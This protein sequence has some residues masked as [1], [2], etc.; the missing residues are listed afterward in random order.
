M[1]AN[2]K[3]PHILCINHSPEILQLL[4][5]LLESEG[6]QV[7]T[8][9]TAE[10]DLEEIVRLKPDLITIDYMWTTSDNEWTHLNLLTIDPRTRDIPVILCTAAVEQVMDMESHLASIGVRVVFK[11]FEIDTLLTA[12]QELL[13]GTSPVG[14]QSHGDE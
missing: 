3:Q 8:Q 11:P 7:S 5:M 1:S 4:R 9:M 2:N 13:A 6:Y 14:E 10:K 12:V